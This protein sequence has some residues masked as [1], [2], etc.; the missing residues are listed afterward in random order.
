MVGP[1]SVHGVHRPTQ[2]CLRELQLL[3][4]PLAQRLKTMDSTHARPLARLFCEL[5]ALQPS[6]PTMNRTGNPIGG[7]TLCQVSQEKDE[8]AALPSSDALGFLAGPLPSLSQTGHYPHSA[9]SSVTETSAQTTA[10]HSVQFIKRQGR[11]VTEDY[12][13]NQRQI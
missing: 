6:L 12:T 1:T 11:I 3:H 4:H 13:Q 2:Q 9:G 7:S 10:A 5:S 8:T